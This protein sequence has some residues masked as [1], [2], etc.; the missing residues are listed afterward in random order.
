MFKNWFGWI[1]GICM[2]SVVLIAGYGFTQD[3]GVVIAH[4]GVFKRLERPPVVFKHEKHIE[5]LGGDKSCR[6]C[7]HV[8]NEEEGK[9]VYEE[10]EEMGCAECH[11]AKDEKMADGSVKPSLMNAYHINC[12]KCH[13]K[14]AKAGEKTGPYTCG[15]CHVKANWKLIE[16]ADGAHTESE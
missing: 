2:L 4:Q 1:A 7:H 9:L 16:G 6:Q 10:G 15:E 12:V 11:G 3:E 14:L 8:Y 5:V 13:R